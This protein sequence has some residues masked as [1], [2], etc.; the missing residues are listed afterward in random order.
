MRQILM[1]LAIQLVAGRCENTDDM[2]LCES[3]G[4][5]DYSGD[6][7]DVIITKEPRVTDQPVIDPD[8][9]EMAESGIFNLLRGKKFLAAVVTG[10]S[11]GLLLA[12]FAMCLVLWRARKDANIRRYGYQK[13]KSDS[14]FP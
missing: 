10:S 1:A 14:N 8:S 4:D 13:G 6:D 3:S 11:I 2:D 9:P 5:Y 12:A 7:S